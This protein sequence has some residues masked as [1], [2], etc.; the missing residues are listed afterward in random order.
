MHAAYSCGG[1]EAPFL[2]LSG[3]DFLQLGEPGKGILLGR[4]GLALDQRQNI[5]DKRL[6]HA[7]AGKVFF[8]QSWN[9]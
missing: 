3:K 9:L 6:L 4:L 5:V 8:S 1:P 7:I 2:H